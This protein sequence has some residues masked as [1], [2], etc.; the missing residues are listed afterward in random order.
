MRQVGLDMGLPSLAPCAGYLGHLFTKR[1]PE[2]AVLA[3]WDIRS[4]NVPWRT[5]SSPFSLQ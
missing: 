3:T 4:K 2:M 1:A 5:L